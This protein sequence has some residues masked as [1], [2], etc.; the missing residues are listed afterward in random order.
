MRHVGWPLGNGKL[1]AYHVQAIRKASLTCYWTIVVSERRI[2]KVATSKCKGGY[3]HL[4]LWL[5]NARY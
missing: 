5:I 4:T 2:D 3:N 1:I